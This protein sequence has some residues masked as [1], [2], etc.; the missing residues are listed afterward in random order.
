MKTDLWSRKWLPDDSHRGRAGGQGRIIR[1]RHRNTGAL[2]GLKLLHRDAQHVT[3]RRFRLRQEVTAL[4]L[5]DGRWSPRALD[6]NAND[7]QDLSVELYVVVEW[8]EGCT[9]SEH[10]GTRRPLDLDHALSATILLCTAVEQCHD[11]GVY[12]WDLKPDNVILAGQS[13][14]RP[15]LVDFGLSWTTERSQSEPGFD[16]DTG[17]EMGNRFLRL[18]EDARGASRRNP[19]SNDTFL[20]GLLLF[21]LPGRAPRILRDAC[22]RPPHE[23]LDP[24]L[25]EST[26]KDHRWQAL[27]GIFRQGFQVD[28]EARFQTVKLL[29]TALEAVRCY[30]DVLPIQQ[31]HFSAYGPNLHLTRSF[32]L[33]SVA[34]SWTGHSIRSLRD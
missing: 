20:V 4:Q 14:D 21:L 32:P 31:T 2:G 28:I 34:T 8:V 1:V 17:Q 18:P 30:Q 23:A 13:I 27:L 33:G 29:H 16:T 15:V 22:D 3:E 26:K 9:L 25:P 6:T 10:V 5:L 7:W 19:R 24:L 12:H 11:V